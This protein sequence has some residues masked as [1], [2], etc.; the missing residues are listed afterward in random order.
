MILIWCTIKKCIEN[1]VVAPREAY[2]TPDIIIHGLFS[3]IVAL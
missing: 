1:A 2:I 3:K